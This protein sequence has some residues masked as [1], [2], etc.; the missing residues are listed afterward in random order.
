MK[1]I[2][3][4]HDLNLLEL[5]KKIQEQLVAGQHKNIFDL[6]DLNVVAIFGDL[7]KAKYLLSNKDI[8][9]NEKDKNETTALSKAC[10]FFGYFHNNY[11][12]IQIL[13]ENKA[14]INFRCENKMSLLFVIFDTYLHCFDF[15]N[16]NNKLKFIYALKILLNYGLNINGQNEEG[17]SILMLCI[18]YYKIDLVRILLD[19]KI[20]IYIKDNNGETALDKINKTTQY[21]SRPEVRRKIYDMILKYKYNESIFIVFEYTNINIFF[22]KN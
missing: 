9:V 18:K 5:E 19:E 22:N 17:Y 13:L 2:F 4:Y 20:N 12:L 7:N 8:D 10:Y 14:D 6:P 11:K 3:S 16:Q 15:E 21:E 1:S